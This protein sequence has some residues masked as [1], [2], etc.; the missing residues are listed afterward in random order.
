MN[1]L[2]GVLKAGVEGVL[3]SKALSALRGS[4]SNRRSLVLAYHNVVTG[5]GGR[6]G[7][8]SLHISFDLFRRHLDLLAS[9]A[10]LV[11]LEQVVAATAPVGSAAITF[12]DAYASATSLAVPE[13][14]ARGIPTTMFIAPGLLGQGAPWWDAIGSGA[15]GLDEDARE[16][17]LE[18]LGGNTGSILEWSRAR[19][20]RLSP[21]PQCRIA[22][23]EEL[24]SLR[25]SPLVTVGAHSWSHPNLR[26]IGREQFELELSGPLSWLR[27]HFPGQDQPWLAYPY[28]LH[29][30]DV[31]RATTAA[32][33]QATFAIRGG[34]VSSR[35]SFSV[36]PRLN[37]PAGLSPAG[38]AARLN[39]FLL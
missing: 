19:S 10:T 4:P 9:R 1:G 18:K 34:W 13:L 32:G 3:G 26:E 31:V 22:T 37:V 7:D 16:F 28:G 12:D 29:S 6:V 17:C 30:D 15:G 11:P 27:Q 8:R 14:V 20:Q 21:P 36:F 39:G 2:R 25:M 38:L 24:T 23:L 5:P 33:Y 35:N